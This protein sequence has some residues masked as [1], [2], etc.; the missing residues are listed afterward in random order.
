[1][2]NGTIKCAFI[3]SYILEKINDHYKSCT[4]IVVVVSESVDY[5]KTYTTCNIYWTCK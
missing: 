1:M 4:I 5:F 2:E 3:I